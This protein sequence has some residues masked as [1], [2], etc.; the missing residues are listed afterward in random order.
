MILIDKLIYLQKRL[1]LSDKEFAS[2]Y[3]IKQK[4][5]KQWKEGI[6]VPT[7]LELEPICLEFNLLIDDFMNDNSTLDNTVK[8][9]EHPCCLNPKEDRSDVIYE[10]YYREENSRYEEKD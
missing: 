9:G 3:K 7:K 2:R 8:D 10:D 5:L 6:L 4:V 1:N